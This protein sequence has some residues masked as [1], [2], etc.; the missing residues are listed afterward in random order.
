MTTP[1]YCLLSSGD[2]KFLPFDV[3][4]TYTDDTTEKKNDTIPYLSDKLMIPTPTNS[5]SCSIASSS[6]NFPS[7]TPEVIDLNNESI[8]S[9]SQ[10]AHS[11]YLPNHYVSLSSKDADTNTKLKRQLF[12]MLAI[13]FPSWSYENIAVKQLT[14]GIT[15]ML[16]SITNSETA[17]TVLVRTYGQGTSL[18]ID[19]DREF[20]SQLFLNSLKLAAPIYARFGNGLVYGFLPGR[21]LSP[22][23]LSHSK[24]YP[25]IAQELG[26]WHNV[27]KGEE[28]FEGISKLRRLRGGDDLDNKIIN[29]V[30]ELIADWIE[31]LPEIDSLLQKCLENENILESKAK[32]TLKEILTKELEW[33]VSE[34]STKSPTVSCHSDLLSGNVIIPDSLSELLKNNGPIAPLGSIDQ[35]PISFIDYEYMLPLPRA[36][37]ISNHF[38]EWQG[39]ECDKSKIPTPSKENKIMRNWAKLYLSIDDHEIS[40]REVD[41]LIDE[42]VLFYGLPG[43]YWGIWAGIQS[44]ISIIDFD[45]K[46]YCCERLDE[47]FVW[48]RNH[49]A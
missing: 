11:L 44:T 30:W 16:L 4:L 18:I 21:A 8:L 26:H 13:V 48:K 25:H 35:N 45:Y 5:S 1:V 33:L 28:I 12:Q 19:R 40:E 3:N 42:I 22:N 14:G 10:S 29:S 38:M 36:F 2:L 6:R 23:E 17:E 49:L 39:F 31:V 24:L 34:I 46:N 27:I 20:V 9:S 47:Y 43:F 37:D 15:N 41:D 7:P 32:I